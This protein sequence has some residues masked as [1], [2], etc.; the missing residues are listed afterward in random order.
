MEAGWLEGRGGVAARWRQSRGG[1]RRRDR[2]SAPRET[3]SP[4]AMDED[5]WR[6]GAALW[7][8]VPLVSMAEA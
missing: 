7:L 5:R 4:S 2:G 3:V 1:W 8:A 6:R